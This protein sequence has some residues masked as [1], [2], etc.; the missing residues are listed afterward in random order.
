MR[1]ERISEN[2]I[3][4]TL[5]NFDLSVRNIKMSELTYGSE[6]A[7]NLFREMMQR[8]S[9]EV[10]FHAEDTPIMVE[11]IPMANDSIV[12]I[13]TRVDDPEELDTRFS[14]FAPE[15]EESEQPW[16][17]PVSEFL[18]GADEILSLFGNPDFLND[19][20]LMKE[21]ELPEEGAA[22]SEDL[23]QKQTSV[24]AAP[25]MAP[26]N[27]RIYRFD[28][29]DLVCAAA[30]QTGHQFTGE[31]ILYKNPANEKFYLLLKKSDSDD[32]SFHQ[33]CNLLSEY[34]V[35]QKCDAATEAYFSEHYE[36]FVKKNTLQVLANL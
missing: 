7:R 35:R 22:P 23:A 1:I 15:S 11:A 31:S 13:I 32:P 14:R 17:S 29:L 6:N 5:T 18:D 24:S 20:D 12:L 2:T 33:T 9:S 34:A 30:K 3:R 25:A 21:L 28:T 26:Q 8:A 10:G 27:T 16:S 36:L 4:C 19:P